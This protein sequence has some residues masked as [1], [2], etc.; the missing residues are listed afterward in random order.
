[1]RLRI[2]PSGHREIGATLL[3]GI[4]LIFRSRGPLFLLTKFR[5][6]ASIS[7]L[8]VCTYGLYRDCL[9]FALVGKPDPL[10]SKAGRLGW[11]QV[12]ALES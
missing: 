3:P 1:M 11:L 7:R 10:G 4:L 9:C 12:S 5:V 8:F 2:R 6:D